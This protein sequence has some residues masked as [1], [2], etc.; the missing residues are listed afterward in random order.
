LARTRFDRIVLLAVL[1]AGVSGI[2]G[3]ASDPRY[4]QGLEWVLWNEAER[5]RLDDAGFPQYT[6]GP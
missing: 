5:K 3:C 2:A 6:H 1:A 4:Q